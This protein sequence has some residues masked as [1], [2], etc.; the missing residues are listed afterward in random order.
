MHDLL[1]ANQPQ[2]GTVG[3]EDAALINTAKTAGVTG[4][5]SCIK[6]K[7]FGPWIEKAGDKLQDDGFEGTPW[8]RI[9]GKDVKSPT[10]A[11]LQQAIDAAKKA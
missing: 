11:A 6:S 5:D 8:V 4:I 10:P 2:E 7:R 3:P 1:Y 9:G